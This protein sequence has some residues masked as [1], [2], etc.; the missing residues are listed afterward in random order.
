MCVW[1]AV[2]LFIGLAQAVIAGIVIGAL[3]VLVAIIF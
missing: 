3:A 2:R 1:E